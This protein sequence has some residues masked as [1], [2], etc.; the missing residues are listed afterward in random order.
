MARLVSTEGSL[1]GQ[2]FP[3][4]PGL[5]LGRE[6]HNDIPL[7][8]NRHASRD[9]AKVWKDGPRSW[10]LADLGSTNG[11]LV[12]GA[13]VTR[14]SLTEGDEIRIGDEVF[15]FEL[16]EED[17][18]K[19]LKKKEAAPDLGAVLRGEAQA[20]VPVGQAAAGETAD[21]I[22]VKQ[23]VLHYQKKSAHGSAV[24]HD[25]GQMAGLGK[26][27][28]ILAAVAVAVGIFLVVK[29]LTEKTRVPTEELPEVVIEDE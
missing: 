18:P 5:T 14:Q 20:R 29:S 1:L 2:S 13:K 15:R 27:V 7:P 19:P 9:H 10:S 28:R 6:G 24:T 21:S 26:W 12:N 16:E 4:D 8:G 17:K 23:R 22:E 3:I 25:I 11:T